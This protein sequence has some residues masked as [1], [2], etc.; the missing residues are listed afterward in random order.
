MSTLTSLAPILCLRAGEIHSFTQTGL[1]LQ[2]GSFERADVVLYCTGYTKTYEY[3]P[4]DLRAKLD[5]QKDGIYLYR[6]ILP[7]SIP[8][9]AFIGA[10]V[11]AVVDGISGKSRH[12]H[13]LLSATGLPQDT[14]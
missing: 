3:L 6:N 5:I 13:H 12:L 8:N 7:P 9:L 4:G 1:F 10:E 2:D 11:R 14:A